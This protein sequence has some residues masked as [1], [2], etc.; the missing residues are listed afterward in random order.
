MAL[1][2]VFLIKY[3][4]KA[5]P[6]PDFIYVVTAANVQFNSYYLCKIRPWY[7]VTIFYA[8][9]YHVRV[10]WGNKRQGLMTLFFSRNL[11]FYLIYEQLRDIDAKISNSK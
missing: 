8:K 6:F 3:T 11:I 4:Y 1:K 10:S 7:S 9:V 5:K 2:L